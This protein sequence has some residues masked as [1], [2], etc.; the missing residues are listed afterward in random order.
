LYGN[1]VAGFPWID[2][3]KKELGAATFPS[4]G[5]QNAPYPIYDR[6]GDTFNLMTEPVITDQGKALATAAFLM[7]R[8]P[9]K[10]QP[11]K[12]AAAR[13]V[14][15]KA[16]STTGVKTTTTETLVAHMEAP[17]LDLGQARITWE[18]QD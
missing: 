8:S 13:I 7:A 6:W 1:L 12:S 11:W 3:Y 17:G 9:L 4:D 18:L 5:D 10:N 14:I 15:Q 2:A 16:G